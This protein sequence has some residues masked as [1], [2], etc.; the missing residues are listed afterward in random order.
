MIYK[1]LV[2]KVAS[3]VEL[4]I[5]ILRLRRTRK[6]TSPFAYMGFAAALFVVIK[7]TLVHLGDAF[8]LLHCDGALT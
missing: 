6:I 4:R 8:N 7:L 1:R 5:T 3:N 2:V